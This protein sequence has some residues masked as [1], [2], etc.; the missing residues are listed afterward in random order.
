MS[1]KDLGL[2]TNYETC[3]RKDQLL[4]SFYIPL[5]Q[6]ATKYYRIAGFFSSSALVVASKGIEGLIANGGKMCLL[7]SPE[8]SEEDYEA[9]REH[10]GV[11]ETNALFNEIK[12][13]KVPHE[14]IRALGWMLDNGYLDIKIVVPKH[15]HTGLFHQKIGIAFDREGNIVSFSGSINETAQ[16]WLNNIEEF[17]VFD[18]IFI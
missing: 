7:V 18:N 12:A 2:D 1:F 5:L 15:S 13:I 6:Q 10:G 4:E 17:K 8:L 3:D 14:N 16:A 11:S 9:I